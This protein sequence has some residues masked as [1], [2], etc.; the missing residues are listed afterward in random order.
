MK[1]TLKILKLIAFLI[2][3][4]LFIMLTASFLLQDKVASIILKSLNKDIS[5]KLEVGSFKLSFLKKFPKASLELKDV[6]VHS[7][8][9]FKSNSFKGI[10]TDT[11]LAARV[12]TGE[13]RITDIIKGIY[14]IERVS[15]RDGKINFYT[16]TAGLVNYA[17][18]VKSNNNGGDVFTI[19]LKRINL[20]NIKSYYNNLAT[21]L[22]INGLVKEGTIKSRISGK[23]IDFTVNSDIQIAGFQLY[24]TKITRAINSEI[25]LTLNS[26][27]DGVLFKK[28]VL[29]VE[30][31]NFALSGFISSDNILDLKITGRNIDI[32]KIRKYLPENYLKL[33][34]EYDP[35]GSLIVDSKIKGLLSRTSNPHVEIT[36]SLNRGR[37]TYGK[38]DLTINNL[39]FTGAFSNGSKNR[40]E[41][42]FVSFNDIKATLGSA[43]YTG[44]FKLSNFVHPR[45]EV[46]LKG[47]VYPREIK[48]FF[49]LQNIST[50]K[51]SADIDLKIEGNL[52]H[53]DKIS[54]SDIIDMKPEGTMVFNSMDIGF[55]N[56]K[57]LLNKISGNVLSTNS[58]RATD[59]HFDY[60]GQNIKIDGEFTNLP[61][62]IAG[63]RVK[64]FAKGDVFFSRF[65]PEAFVK[66]LNSG[67][68]SKPNKTAFSLPSDIILDINFR[69]DNLDY[70]TFSS[71]KIEGSLTYKPRT[72]TFKSLSMKSLNGSI[73]GN[74]F[75]V[76]NST[77]SFIAK[78][79]FNVADIDVNKAFI[80]FHNFG[81]DFL[82]AE[83]LKGTLSGSLSLLLP[84]DSMLKYQIKTVTAEG[85]MILVNGALVNFEPV[86]HLST[87]IELSE[88]ENISFARLENDFFI[89]N[90]F[91]YVP[92]MDVKSSAADL[93]VNGKHSFD[94][95]YEY[96]VKILLSE[97]LSKKRNKNKKNVT[98]FGVIEDDGLGRTS[99]LLKVVGKNEDIKVGYDMKAAGSEVKNNIKQ[100]RQTLK[101]ILNQ[102]YGWYKND[103]LPKQEPVKKKLRFRITFDD[104]DSLKSSS[105]TPSVKKE[106]GFKGLFKKK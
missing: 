35:S 3:P 32:S 67:D 44:T 93:S 12:V 103:S 13:F 53:K 20:T 2:I 83:N 19:D 34:S 77:K 70:K 60:K 66:D 95:N 50:A 58:I 89:R 74:G 10:N 106:N 71:S 79:S 63:R 45:I 105:D 57:I 68:A 94:N 56:D 41:T 30:N 23:N 17:I 48:E 11:L 104:N 81:Q 21:K 37:I 29:K 4:V 36:C 46:L 52:I 28:G 102:E 91:L 65:I 7:S 18:S 40:F 55:K 15:A 99:L 86:K 80:T 87:Y 84:L 72:L 51:G 22:V 64:L 78:G 101:T 88:L 31:F 49:D 85:K 82:K 73:S 42:S 1:L 9:N 33:V 97:I 90:N 14:N 26:S 5:T 25:T 100:E 98:E 75:V 69:I 43:Q 38:S 59:F 27:K 76:Q 62:W 61:E 39:S 92:Q 6:L 24:N 16:D 96:H 8:S 47:K 54:L